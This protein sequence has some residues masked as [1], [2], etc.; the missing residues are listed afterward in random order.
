LQVTGKP[1]VGW[2]DPQRTSP[3]PE[4]LQG[5]VYVNLGSWT[6]Q[7]TTYGLWDRGHIQLMDWKDGRVVGD[8]L[9]ER[10][11]ASDELPG[12]REWWTRYYRGFIRYDTE[13]LHRDRSAIATKYDDEPRCDAAEHGSRLGADPLR[14]TP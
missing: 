9:Y 7:D 8:R 13:Q 3:A 2:R 5:K 10:A 11:L 12:M 14:T 6:F 4:H 1:R